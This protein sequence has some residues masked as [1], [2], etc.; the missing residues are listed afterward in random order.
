MTRSFPKR[1]STWFCNVTRY[2]ISHLA[3]KCSCRDT[4]SRATE[5]KFK[6]HLTLHKK[7]RGS[8]HV[9]CCVMCGGGAARARAHCARARGRDTR[10]HSPA[11]SSHMQPY[12]KTRRYIYSRTRYSHTS[13]CTYMCKYVLVY[14]YT[15]FEYKVLCTYHVHIA[16]AIRTRARTHA[17]AHI[18]ARTHARTHAHAHAHARTRIVHQS[19]TKTNGKASC[20][21]CM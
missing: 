1:A 15:P 3:S 20:I 4:M 8:S 17:H 18:H 6:A 11:L 19:P 2:C 12:L 21:L 7:K 10:T 5:V 16:R 13:T 14:I 9:G